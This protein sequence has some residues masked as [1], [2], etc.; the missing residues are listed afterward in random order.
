MTKGT[1]AKGS[2]LI[3]NGKIKAVGTGRRRPPKDVKVIDAAG[4]VAM[5]GIID[6]HSHIAVQ[7]GVNEGTLSVVPEVRVKDVV[8]GDD[9]AIYRAIAGGTT[10][11]RLL[12][13]FGQHDRR[14]GRRGQA[15][16]RQAGPRPDHQGRPAGGEI[17]P[18][19]ERH[20][21]AGTIPE[22]ADGRRVGDRAGLR[23]RPG[24]TAQPGTTYKKAEKTKDPDKLG[25]P[26]RVDLRLEALAG[27]LDG[28]IKIHSHCYR[29]DEILMLLRTAQK[30]GVRV[31]SL[32][33]VLE[34]YKVAAEIAAHGAS[35]STFS[36]WWAYK[37]EAYDAIPY[38]AA[39]LDRGRRQRLHQER[40]RRADAPPQ[41]RGGQDGQVR[42]RV[43]EPGPGDDHDQ[44]GPRAWA[45]RPAGLDR[46]R[47]GWGYRDLQ[48]PSF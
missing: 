34:G 19:R 43:R 32:Q 33:H 3:E 22:H 10:T 15:A 31:Q 35:A 14:P 45:G 18:R 13:R 24:P 28:S 29:S 47:Q 46:G 17:R 23:R 6:T 44:P 16:L 9:I 48:R 21:I 38:N 25:P 37:I 40:R 42:R 5:P 11:A 30:Y 12:A 20:A 41:S 4:L 26:P 1:I 8:T 2:I 27:I 39:L 7:G 36:D